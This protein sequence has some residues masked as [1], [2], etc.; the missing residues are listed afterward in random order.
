MTEK[1]PHYVYHR[2]AR[3]FACGGPLVNLRP[4]NNAP[5]RGHYAGDCAETGQVT[6]YDCAEGTVELINLNEFNDARRTKGGSE[7]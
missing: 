6:W 3:C 5:G 4:T 1:F 2:D 7:T